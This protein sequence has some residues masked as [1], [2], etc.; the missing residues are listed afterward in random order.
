M[1]PANTLFALILLG[2]TDATAGNGPFGLE[3]GMTKDQVIRL[4]GQKNVAEKYAGDK[5]SGSDMLILSSAPKPHRAFV[6]YRLTISPKDGLLRIIAAGVD[7]PTNGFGRNV[8]EAFT[9]IRDAVAASYGQPANDFDYV[10][11]GSLWTEPQYWMIGVLKKERTLSSLWLPGPL[12]YDPEGTSLKVNEHKLP[13]NLD[14][15]S[16]VVVA[17]STEMACLRLI[18]EFEG[19]GAYADSKE[20][21]ENKVFGGGK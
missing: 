12:S 15:I 21:T 5:F 16:L 6:A 2:G 18:Y 14:A 7:I 8:Q 11:T 13:Y 1:K 17:R 10:E 4:V 20:A 3:R 19:Y 9:N